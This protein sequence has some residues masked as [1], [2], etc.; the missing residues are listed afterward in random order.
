MTRE[1]AKKRLAEARLP[2]LDEEDR[3]GLL[4]EW[5][6]FEP[7][8]GELTELPREL[9]KELQNGLEI[10]DAADQRFDP[11]IQLAI[12]QELRG[13]RNEYIAEELR[14]LGI[15]V[16]SVDGEVELL[17]ACPCCGYR[18]LLGRHMYEVCPV[19]FWEDDE[20]EGADTI[21]EGNEMTLNQARANFQRLGIV[22]ESI[23]DFRVDNPDAAYL[24]A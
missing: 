7:E 22:D 24:K 4:I 6:V 21:S 19:C 11:L 5:T 23:L 12:R 1:E 15:E 8:E 20:T 13:I 10:D 3:E 14:A 18:T 9:L 16:D 2:L 17:E